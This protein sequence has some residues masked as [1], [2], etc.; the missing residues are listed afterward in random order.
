MRTSARRQR[1]CGGVTI[2]AV[3]RAT[4]SGAGAVPG[5]VAARAGVST[6]C[7]MALAYGVYVL[8]MNVHGFFNSPGSGNAAGP[9]S[10]AAAYGL[11]GRLPTP[12]KS[13]GRNGGRSGTAQPSLSN[14]AFM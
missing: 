14:V 11:Y 2:D 8:P 6:T 5:C 3:I 4:A 10:K 12:P 13:F 1:D 9:F 7:C